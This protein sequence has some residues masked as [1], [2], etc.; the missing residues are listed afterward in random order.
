[1]QTDISGDNN[2]SASEEEASVREMRLKWMMSADKALAEQ[3]QSKEFT[4]HY[5]QNKQ[6]NAQLRQDLS[7]AKTLAEEIEKSRKFQIEM[8]S[9]LA[10]QLTDELTEK[11]EIESLLQRNRDEEFARNLQKLELDKIGNEKSD[12]LE[13]KVY[14]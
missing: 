4:E 3:L 5:K 6:K 8:D 12:G 7:R 13:K 11:V 10:K 1:M 9:R 2:N 14:S